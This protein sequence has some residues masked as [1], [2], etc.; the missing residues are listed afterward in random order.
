MNWQILKT[1]LPAVLIAACVAP[2]PALAQSLLGGGNNYYNDYIFEMTMARI[3]M[4]AFSVG[5]GFCIGW[6]L[7]PQAKELRRIILLCMAGVVILLA[8]FN[9]DFLGWGAAWIVSFVGFFAALGR[10][11]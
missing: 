4:M 9:N 5:S 7:S 8:V 1:A 10:S 6:F 2:H 3:I 11:A